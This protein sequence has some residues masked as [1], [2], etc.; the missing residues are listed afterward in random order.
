MRKKHGRYLSYLG[1]FLFLLS[2]YSSE[3]AN[4]SGKLLHRLPQ[5][6]FSFQNEQA[7]GLKPMG[8][9]N[10]DPSDNVSDPQDGVNLSVSYSE[11]RVAIIQVTLTSKY[12]DPQMKESSKQTSDENVR[13]CC[14]SKA[15]YYRF[16]KSI[17][18]IRALGVLVQ[19]DPIGV[20]P[21]SGWIRRTDNYSRA[22]VVRL[23]RNC[24]S[25]N[26]RLG[27]G[28]SKFTV[29]YWIPLEGK[30]KGKRI[31]KISFGGPELIH[32]FVTIGSAEVEVSHT[33]YERLQEGQ[34][35]KLER[36]FTNLP[37]RILSIKH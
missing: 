35:V 19:R 14:M 15:T 6:H 7:D 16:L 2:L 3:K 37:A 30:I 17:N 21:T 18:Q 29:F 31:E 36:V 9:K 8:A 23:E 12:N 26:A 22:S 20:I 1:C 10:H 34:V 27:C 11:G 33:D 4:G 13:S 28:I 32:Y 24:P 25:S 5:F